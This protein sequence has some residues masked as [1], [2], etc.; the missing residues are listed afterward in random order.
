MAGQVFAGT[1]EGEPWTGAGVCV[2][3]EGV[4]FAIGAFDSD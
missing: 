2:W 1:S 3:I 4:F